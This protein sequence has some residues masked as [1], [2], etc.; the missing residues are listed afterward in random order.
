MKKGT[1]IAVL[2]GGVAVVFA[3]VK[4]KPVV[5]GTT[6]LSGTVTNPDGQPIVGASVR[7]HDIDVPPSGHYS[8]DKST[9]TDAKGK[10]SFTG[11]DLSVIYV[12]SG[13]KGDGRPITV[14]SIAFHYGL[15]LFD[16]IIQPGDNTFNYTLGG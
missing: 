15:R 11:I 10:Y 8:I 13:W 16:M 5:A 1:V 12:D 2:L 4:I 6:T 3:L 14:D 7:I 9:K